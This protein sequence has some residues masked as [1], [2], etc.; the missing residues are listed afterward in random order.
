[1]KVK[2]L[3]STLSEIRAFI[4]VSCFPFS[5]IENDDSWFEKLKKKKSSRQYESY[6]YRRIKTN[7]YRSVV[8][9][10]LFFSSSLPV[11]AIKVKYLFPV[12]SSVKFPVKRDILRASFK[13]KVIEKSTLLPRDF[14][15]DKFKVFFFYVGIDFIHRWFR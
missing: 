11:R 9:P 15:P 10:K 14:Y 12:V 7:S 13:G 4:R 1:M 3:S 2:Y 8:F 5:L 6:I